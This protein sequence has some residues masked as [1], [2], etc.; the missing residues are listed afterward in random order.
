MKKKRLLTMAGV[1]AASLLIPGTAQARGFSL[2]NGGSTTI[3]ESSFGDDGTACKNGCTGHTFTGKQSKIYVVSGEHTL[4]FNGVTIDKGTFSAGQDTEAVRIGAGATVH[5]ELSGKNKIIGGKNT[6]GIIVPKDATLEISAGSLDDELT[7]STYRGDDASGAAG[8]G[9]GSYDNTNEI[10]KI[11]IN[12]GTITATGRG[13]GNFPGIG[14]NKSS[15]EIIL[16]GGIISTEPSSGSTTYGKAIQGATVTSDTGHFSIVKGLISGNTANLNTLVSSHVSNTNF[17]VHGDVV[18]QNKNSGKIDWENTVENIDIPFGASLTLPRDSNDWNASCNKN[19]NGELLYTGAGTIIYN[20]DN[21]SLTSDDVQLLKD[22]GLSMKVALIPDDFKLE[23]SSGKKV[24]RTMPY[25]G[26]DLT[27]D[28]LYANKTRGNYDVESLNGWSRKI[29]KNGKE[30]SFIDAGS[31]VVT[32]EKEGRTVVLDPIIIQ[33]RPLTS[34][35]FQ[36]VINSPTYTGEPL[37]P[38]ITATYTGLDIPF[39]YQDDYTMKYNG[40]DVTDFTNAGDY[41]IE[42]TGTSTGNFSGKTTGTFT[43]RPASIENADVSITVDGED[44]LDDTPDTFT[45]DNKA[46]KVEIKLSYDG[47]ALI[48]GTDYTVTYITGNGE[49]DEA[50]ADLTNAGE[51]TILIKGTGNYQDEIKSSFKIKKKEIKFQ[52]VTAE[53][54]TYDGTNIVKITKAE[55]NKADFIDQ[56]DDVSIDLSVT[57]D[58]PALTAMVEKADIGSYKELTFNVADVNAKLSGA[59]SGNYTFEGDENGQFTFNLGTVNKEV[60]ISTAFL[61]KDLNPVLAELDENMYAPDKNYEFFEYTAKVSNPIT[62]PQFG[63]TIE[64]EYK[65]DD[66]DWQDSP[67]FK[68]IE[69]DS[70]HTF[71]VRTKAVWPDG[72]TSSEKPDERANIAPS[73]SGELEI[74]FKRLEQEAPDIPNLTFEQNEGSPTFTA[75]INLGK[76]VPDI[77][78]VEY[79]FDGKNFSDN[80]KKDNCTSGTEY[81]GYVRYKETKTTLPGK[82]A[83]SAPTPAPQPAV[84]KP[85]ITPGSKSFLEGHSVEVTISCDTPGAAI[86]YTTDGKEPVPGNDNTILY[87]GKP[88]LITKSTTIRALATEP[89]MIPAEGE[90]AIFTMVTT[91]EAHT[92]YIIQRIDPDIPKSYSIPKTLQKAGLDGIDLITA[93]L[94]NAIMDSPKSANAPFNYLNME[95]FNIKIQFSADGETDWVDATPENFPPEGVTVSLSDKTL[96]KHSETLKEVDK[97]TNVFLASHMFTEKHGDYAPGDIEVLDV[98]E[99]ESALEFTIHGTSPMAV[100]WAKGDNLDGSNGNTPGTDPANP[101]G[102]NNPNNNDKNT[103]GTN[104]NANNPNVASE[105]GENKNEDNAD[106]EKSLADKAK[107]LLSHPTTGDPA[108]LLLWIAL[109]AGSLG[110]LTFAITK[111]RKRR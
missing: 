75:T 98:V 6:P 71:Y 86:Y 73:D 57:D 40:S 31:Y 53:D 65:I 52:N 20:P 100:A 48:L 45:Y 2:F 47:K 15:G 110:I 8:I 22:K 78:G 106:S 72:E 109:G 28:L 101:D 37:I 1:L 55:I 18:L 76:P 67:D 61:S 80:P 82:I 35:G 92:Q 13:S 23:D 46:K 33:Q 79:S 102:T 34:E 107:E 56:N 94:F 104:R 103:N 32:Y 51:V 70:T 4:K 11:I 44:I 83:Q 58:S 24:F 77:P 36:I 85:V 63:H 68:G 60:V 49:T 88:I 14:T 39:R 84:S 54:R 105:A 10:G 69:P 62:A 5:L 95:Y 42:F 26:R 19:K 59:K 64:Y 91:S 12:G 108:S 30:V 87:D 93:A 7:A 41:D 89:D 111:I 74:T 16:N 21:V 25:T 66:G 43:I 99:T 9:G 38:E 81:I 97:S 50:N 17:T 27:N 29:E 3:T 90:A 96:A